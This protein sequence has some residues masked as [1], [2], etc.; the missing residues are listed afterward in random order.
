MCGGGR[1]VT[2]RKQCEEYKKKI[3]QQFLVQAKCKPQF[4]DCNA[5]VLYTYE[6]VLENPDSCLKNIL[7]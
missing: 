7:G 3:T 1:G 6:K 4:T 5:H 2:V